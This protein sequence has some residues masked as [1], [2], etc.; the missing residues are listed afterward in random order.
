MGVF[1]YAEGTRSGF[2]TP[3][4]LPFKKGAFHLAL[5]TG[6]PIVPVVF[7]NTSHLFNA[8][9]WIFESGSMGIK[10]NF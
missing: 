4:L 3:E 2:E 1:I 5:Q 7:S 10:G 9:R 6:F 8:K